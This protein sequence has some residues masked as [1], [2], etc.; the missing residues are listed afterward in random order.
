MFY[1]RDEQ[2]ALLK[3]LWRKPVSSFIVLRGR[4]RIGKSTL[5]DAF[6]QE[7][8]G[9]YLKLEGLAPDDYMSNAKQLEAFRQ[10][11]ARQI[12][13]T[14]PKLSSWAVAFSELD[15]VLDVD[16]RKVVLLDE[17]SWMGGY[18]RTFP[19]QL[20]YAWD[21]LFKRH[22]DLVV[23]VCGSVSAWISRNILRS[24][25]FVGRISLD[26]VVPELPLDACAKFWGKRLVRTATREI[27][28]IL[29]VTGGVPRYLEE[30]D[31]GLTADENIRRMCFMPQGYLFREFEE[32]FNDV[33]S[34]T[35]PQKRAILE[36]LV[37]GPLSGAE[38]AEKLSTDRNGHLFDILDDLETAGFLAKAEGINPATGKRARVDQYR[39]RDNYTRFFLKYVMPRYPEIRAGLFAFGS[40]SELPGWESIMGLSFENLILNNVLQLIPRLN[41]EGRIVNSAA[42]FRGRG[43]KGEGVQV[44]LLVQTSRN[45]Y[46]VEVKRKSEIGASI[47]EE[48]ARKA[49]RLAVRRGVSTR[50]V[51]V[52]DGHLAPGV[53]LSDGV[54]VLVSFEELLRG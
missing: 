17:I 35:A 12:D 3:A 49:E 41:L 5:A 8:G 28:D 14:V 15:K 53:Q 37:D 27:A 30:V 29:S 39:L 54:D 52:Y 20:K 25:G 22:P 16:G 2:M 21:N 46:I 11:L 44:D 9:L 24:K 45:A 43:R 26:I 34:R 33:L 7:S 1:G 47:V 10:Q 13:E 18:D 51:L 6:A 38:L 23:L 36:A 50:T 48:L 40:L 31:P 19:A 4:R 32:L 42:P